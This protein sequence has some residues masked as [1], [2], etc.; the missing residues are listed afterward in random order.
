MKNEYKHFLE[1][2][3]VGINRLFALVY[4]NENSNFKRCN[5]LKYYLPKGIIKIYNLI[6]NGKSCYDQAIDYVIKRCI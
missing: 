1:S 3:F 5:A 6:I 4:T 2:N